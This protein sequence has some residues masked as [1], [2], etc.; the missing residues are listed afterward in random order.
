MNIVTD[1][2]VTLSDEF[3]ELLGNSKEVHG[4]VVPDRSR[5]DHPL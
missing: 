3:I 5:G 2:K 4:V 1:H